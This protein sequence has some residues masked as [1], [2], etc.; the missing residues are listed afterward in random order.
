MNIFGEYKKRVRQIRVLGR[1]IVGM[2]ETARHKAIQRIA[3][4]Q[5]SHIA[6]LPEAQRP[7]WN[8]KRSRVYEI[9][10]DPYLL[11]KLIFERRQ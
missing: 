9:P 4:N 5:L 6:D 11:D 2:T 3:K 7:R 1:L 8:K 10:F